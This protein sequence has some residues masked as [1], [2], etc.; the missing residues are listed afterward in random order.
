MARTKAAIN[1]T[2]AVT[3]GNGPTK[4][5]KEEEEKD[6]ESTDDANNPDEEED[7]DEDEKKSDLPVGSVSEVKNIYRSQKDSDGNWTWVD[8]YPEDA[9]EPAE[10]AVTDTYAVLVRNVK[11]QDGRKKL[12]AHSIVVQS[13]WLRQ[14]L[15]EVILKDY[16]GVACELD[17]LTFEAPFKPFVHRWTNLVEYMQREDLEE[18]TKEHL[19]ILHDILKYE[20]GDNIKAYEDYVVKGVITF[21][22]LWMIFQPGAVILAAHKGPLSA[23]ELNETEY[24]SNQCGQF[25]RVSADCVDYSGKEFGRHTERISVPEFIGT[26]KI[27]SLNAFPLVFHEA[28]TSIVEKLVKRG[29]L[30]ENLAGHHYKAYDGTAI[31]WDRQG[32]EMPIPINGRI[33][34]DIQ[35]FNRNNMFRK[36]WLSDWSAKDLERLQEHKK[37]HGLTDKGHLRLTPYYQMLA[38]SRTRGYSLKRKMWLE[39]YVEQVDEIQWNNDAFDKLVLPEDQKE[40]VL[41]FSESQLEGGATFDDVISGKG[42][43]IICLLSG[44]PGVGKTLTAEA[45]AENL[46]VPLHTLSSGDLGSQPWEVENGLSQIL[47]LVARWNAIL[48]L[49]ECDVFLEARST[50]DL[51]RNKVVSIFLR[52][53][54]YY[55]GILFMTTNRV[56]N[57]DAAFQ[58]RIHVSLE[59][60]DLTTESRAQIWRNFIGGFKEKPEIT[61][62]DVK[63]LAQMKLNGRQI[64]NILKTAQL[65]AARKN[66]ILKRSFIDTVLA[67]EKRR[68]ADPFP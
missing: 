37:T 36:R 18:K 1:P 47:E 56:D 64:K 16:P 26:K 23:F 4:K 65:L 49:D 3:Y 66:T 61:E 35:S 20:I 13:P 14:A 22:H 10:N 33:V 41:A 53:L 39:F 19:V 25:L 44:P 27:T 50:S 31:T 43:G 34:V 57:I 6:K 58:S 24:M 32:E 7:E 15:G 45:V 21:P 28:R 54:E 46:R 60:P 68:P 67:I 40:L 17:R 48:L 11:S 12:E 8:K 59:Y 2:I 52:T 62:E 9:Q 63:E 30:F 42:K 38:S 5:E 55:E 29:Q 51:E